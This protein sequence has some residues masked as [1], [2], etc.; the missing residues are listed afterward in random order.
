MPV[1]SRAPGNVQEQLFT[2]IDAGDA[3]AAQAALAAGADPGAR[4]GMDRPALML[5][6]QDGHLEIVRALLDRGADPN[7]SLVVD[8]GL[9]CPVHNTALMRAR[10]GKHKA[11][12]KLLQSRGALEAD[13][14]PPIKPPP[15]RDKAEATLRMI[16]VIWGDDPAELV[17]LLDL[18]VDAAGS[19]P[20]TGE[21]FLAAAERMGKRE[22]VAILRKRGAR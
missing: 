12:V 15:P 10:E 22:L 6:A 3:A 16:D 20:Q 18:G 5:A 1:D 7:A 4:D 13:K 9:G 19:F 14:L 11:V 2:A 8:F 17:Q 21:S